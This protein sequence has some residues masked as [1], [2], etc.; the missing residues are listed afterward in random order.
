MTS[1]HLKT[2][3]VRENKIEVMRMASDL[4]VNLNLT[5]FLVQNIDDE[6][7]VAVEKKANQGEKE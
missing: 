6:I 1:Y 2:R 5:D 4:D 7:E 3:P